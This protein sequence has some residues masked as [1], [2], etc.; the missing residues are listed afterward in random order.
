MA[1]PASLSLSW[2]SPWRQR[3]EGV[4]RNGAAISSLAERRPFILP[5]AISE[6]TL[7]QR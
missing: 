5:L 3:G 6:M 7:H 1:Q 4:A 2:R